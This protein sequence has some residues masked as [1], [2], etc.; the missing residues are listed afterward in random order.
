MRR[1]I[2]VGG[3]VQGVGFRPFVHGLAHRLAVTGWVRN[4][5]RGVLIEVQGEDYALDLFT[6]A[7]QAEAPPLAK[8]DGVAVDDI[9]EVAGEQ[10]FV[11]DLSQGGEVLTAIGPDTA[12]C[13]DCLADILDPQN[14]RAGYP[15]VTC[16]HCG[17]RYTIT[18][19]LPYDRSNTSMAGFALCSDCQAEYD[20]PADRRFH[21]QPNACSVCGPRMSMETAEIVGRLKAGEV[22]AIKGLGGFHLACDARNGEAVAM[23][24]GRKDREEKPFAV[25]VADLQKAKGLVEMGE[26]E[27]ALLTGRERPI[28]LMRKKSGNGLVEG[29]APGLQ[30]LGVMLPYTPLH[31]LIF[32]EA[33]EMAL[34]MTSANPGGEPLVIANGEARQR[35]EGIADA[36]ADH[37]RDIL[38][39]TDDSVV[40]VIDG[41]P[42]FIRR[43]RGYVPVAIKLPRSAPPIL[44]VGGHLKNTICV[45]RG[46]QAFLSQHI[47]DLDTPKGLLFFEETVAH[48][49]SILEVEP[50]LVAHDLHPDFHATRFAQTMGKETVSVQHHHAHGAAVM[51]ERG[52]EEPVLALCLDGFGLGGDGGAW[53]GELLRIDPQGYERLGH[54]SPLKQPGGDLA[55][56][57]PWRMGAAALHAMGKGDE[58]DRKYNQFNESRLIAKI[59]DKELNSP[60]TSS[61]GR[62]FDAACGLLGVKP[63]ASFEGQAPMLVEG[64]VTD[65][66]VV[67]EGWEIEAG[68][69]S[70]MPTLAALVD[71]QEREGANLFHGTLV[72]ALADWVVRASSETGIKTV[73]LS[74]GCFLN[75]VLVEGVLSALR[76][77]GV[78]AVIPRQ[79]PPNDGGLSLGQAWVAAMAMKN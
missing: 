43:A 31:H 61:C 70:L 16:T 75:A 27:E 68:V 2:R 36:I 53:G 49:L 54:L 57:E 22:L 26:A 42:T 74:G 12:V 18:A 20:D 38:V 65:P 55:A 19:K 24:R 10:G 76:E 21:A 4:D 7:L 73:V 41:A 29:I 25:M 72:A 14:R 6:A 63:K 46:D 48:L 62:L 17:P 5:G 23:L 66:K 1:R 47:G 56:R 40:R 8:I 13:D 15:F 60:E 50:E 9:A 58:I 52:L 37:D 77:S 59:M 33:P 45:T 39:R 34:V 51:A 3:I 32:A 69:L 67:D 30:W 64:M 44:A 11:I 28:V 78:A 79:A 35:L 71:C